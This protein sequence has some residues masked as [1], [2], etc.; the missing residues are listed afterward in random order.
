LRV[1]AEALSS[2]AFS[3]FG[4]VVEHAGPDRRRML[5]DAT[6]PD[7]AASI[8]R[9]WVS[10]LDTPATLP[11]TISVLERHR[12]SPQTFIPLEVSRYLVTVAPS[13]AF[14][15]PIVAEARAFVVGS[16]RGIVYR[17]G[18]WHAGMTV[19]DRPA[20]FAVLIWSMK[21]ASQNDEFLDLPT[22]LQIAED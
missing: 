13:D 7:E 8:A 9:M 10:R 5:P 11:L 12:F 4:E 20:R 19:L 14:G 18:T 15:R 6:A 22:P 17:C 21:D 2:A 1:I 16:G 3:Q